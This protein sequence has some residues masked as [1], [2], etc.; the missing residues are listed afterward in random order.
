MMESVVEEKSESID[1]EKVKIC[2]VIIL[3]LQVLQEKRSNT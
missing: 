3:I 2:S 1:R